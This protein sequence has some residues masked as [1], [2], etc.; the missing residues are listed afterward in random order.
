M[1]FLLTYN[2]KCHHQ[3]ALN[4]AKQNNYL[5]SLFSHFWF[6]IPQLV[7]Q[8]DWQDVWHSPQPP[9]FALSQRLRVSRV[10]IRFIYN[11]PQSVFYYFLYCNTTNVKSQDTFYT[12]SQ[13]LTK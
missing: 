10:V 5:L 11:C 13:Y 6:A 9:F 8:A 2:E 4:S 3:A 1:D 12:L 7:L